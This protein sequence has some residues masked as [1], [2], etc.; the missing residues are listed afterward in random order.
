ME[1]QGL[2]LTSLYSPDPPLTPPQIAAERAAALEEHRAQAEAAALAS[3]SRIV[4]EVVRAQQVRLWQGGGRWGEGS[5]EMEGVMVWNLGYAWA[6]ER[7]LS[8]DG[9]GHRSALA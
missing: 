7:G 9:E 1:A 5:W 2:L 3:T 6:A 8:G 4:H